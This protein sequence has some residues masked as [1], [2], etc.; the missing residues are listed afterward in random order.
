[1]GDQLEPLT[2]ECHGAFFDVTSVHFEGVKRL[3]FLNIGAGTAYFKISEDKAVPVTSATG[4]AGVPMQV[5]D[6]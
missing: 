4:Y 3:P 2:R 6:Y 5:R 1:M